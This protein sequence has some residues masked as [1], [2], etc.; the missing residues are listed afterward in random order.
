MAL[1]WQARLSI[2]AILFMCTEG[3]YQVNVNDVAS[4]RDRR[5]NALARLKSASRIAIRDYT[6]GR[7]RSRDSIPADLSN[8]RVEVIQSKMQQLPSGKMARL[9]ELPACM[10]ACDVNSS[11]ALFISRSS[12]ALPW[13]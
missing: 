10:R 2:A 7:L 3:N 11:H 6:A 12:V 5:D 13:D 9:M 1:R 8:G 4:I